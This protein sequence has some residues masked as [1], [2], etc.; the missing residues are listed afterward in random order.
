[1]TLVDTWSNIL[2][3]L[4]VTNL[5]NNVVNVLTRFFYFLDKL[6]YGYLIVTKK[7]ILIILNILE[8]Q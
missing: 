1:M 2:G 7:P 3:N 5:G 4:S 8:S 6:I